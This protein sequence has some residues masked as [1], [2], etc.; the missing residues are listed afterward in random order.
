[1]TRLRNGGRL[2][3]TGYGYT[4]LW[5]AIISFCQSHFEVELITLK[6]SV[7]AIAKAGNWLGGTV[8]A[9]R[10]NRDVVFGQHFESKDITTQLVW[11]RNVIGSRARRDYLYYACAVQLMAGSALLTSASVTSSRSPALVGLVA[12]AVLWMTALHTNSWNKRTYTFHIIFYR[13]EKP[14]IYNQFCQRIQ[15]T[16]K[17]VKLGYRSWLSSRRL[18]KCRAYLCVEHNV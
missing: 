2:T 18:A 5:W 12:H 14:L 17:N 7:N 15:L 9:F 4:T 11:T 16:I 1:M 8:P 6:M 10:N 3:I 13:T